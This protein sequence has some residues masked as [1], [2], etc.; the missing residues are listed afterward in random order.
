MIIKLYFDSSSLS[1][2]WSVSQTRF[3]LEYWLAWGKLIDEHNLKPATQSSMIHGCIHSYIH[4]HSIAFIVHQVHFLK[5][6]LLNFWDCDIETKR[7]AAIV[8]TVVAMVWQ[9]DASQPYVW[10]FSGTNMS[11]DMKVD[12]EHVGAQPKC[13]TSADNEHHWQ[14]LTKVEINYKYVWLWL[15][16]LPTELTAV[17]VYPLQY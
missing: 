7:V 9:V 12:H 11:A 4:I 17:S 1:Y 14:I 15:C 3:F 13:I 2:L 16:Q 6:K 5:L 8:A 10:F